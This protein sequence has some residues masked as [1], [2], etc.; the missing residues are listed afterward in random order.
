M[1]LWI[2]W[3]LS[4]PLLSPFP[5][6]P[7]PLLSS[8]LLPSPLKLKLMSP[9]F[10]SPTPSHSAVLKFSLLFWSKA[11]WFFFTAHVLDLTNTWSPACSS[12][13]CHSW[14]EEWLFCADNTITREHS[15]SRC[16]LS[17]IL[18]YHKGN[19]CRYKW[20]PG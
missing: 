4:P 12:C 6:L 2:T 16:F 15:I 11:C 3:A 5:P 10:I 7:S 9:C 19:T 8:P 13:H 1:H 17:S 18:I 14:L 20:T